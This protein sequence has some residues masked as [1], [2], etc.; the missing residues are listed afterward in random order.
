MGRTAILVAALSIAPGSVAVGQSAGPEAALIASMSYSQ[1]KGDRLKDSG[2]AIRAYIAGGYVSRK[3]DQR[4]DYTDYRVLKKPATLL[5]QKILVLEEEYLVK[6]IGCCVNDGIGAILEIGPDDAPLKE[7][8]KANRCLLNE[9]NAR[10][11]LAALGLRK[12]AGR[13]VSL[14]C[15]SRD[16]LADLTP[17]A[18]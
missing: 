8:A 16:A 6:Y 3:P 12:P 7:F 5:G 14:S 15:R 4:R 9:E 18:Q 10:A 1:A 13:V 17:I 2:D 11:D